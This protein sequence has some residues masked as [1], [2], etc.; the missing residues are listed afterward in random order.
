LEFGIWNLIMSRVA[1][2]HYKYKS[3]FANL[4]PE[5]RRWLA[6]EG[7]NSHTGREFMDHHLSLLACFAHPDD[8]GLVTGSFARYINAGARV[9]LIC[10]TRG[11]VGEIAPGVDATRETLGQVREQE[12]RKAMSYVNL[13]E[14]HFLDYR[15]SGMAGTAE[16]GHDHN[17]INAP[18]EEVIG[19]V[20]AIIRATKPQ[21][22]LTFDPRGGYGHP[23]HI[24]IYRATMAAFEMAGDPS[25]YPEQL[26]NGLKAHTPQKVYWTSFSRE[27]FV[28]LARYFEQQGIDTK[29]FG[30][31]N[32]GAR[33]SLMQYE[34]TTRIDVSPYVELKGQAWAAHASQHNPNSPMSKVPP[35]LM[36]KFR[37]TEHL[38]L[39]ATRLRVP[40]AIEDDVFCGVQ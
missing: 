36:N 11:E 21:V 40:T 13:D 3:Q 1:E 39:A 6:V 8:E 12:L 38:I 7:R 28:E 32:P 2:H 27:F 16:N 35:E 14:I 24:K 26:Q 15:D 9:A 5:R 22:L 31:F 10:A 33:A 17:F 37:T 25:C 30:A 18:D 19:K 34:V 20:V 29:Q 4:H 23:D